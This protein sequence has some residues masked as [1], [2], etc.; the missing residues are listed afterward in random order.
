[1]DWKLEPLL[2]DKLDGSEWSAP[3][4]VYIRG[5]VIHMIAKSVNPTDIAGPFVAVRIRF[6]HS[7]IYSVLISR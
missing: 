1:V 4:A 5:E 2:G 6:L 7:D 3:S